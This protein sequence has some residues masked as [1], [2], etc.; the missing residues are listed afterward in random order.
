[1]KREN[2]YLVDGVLSRYVSQD[3][4]SLF[5]LGD[6]KRCESHVN[7]FAKTP[8]RSC[9]SDPILEMELLRVFHHRCGLRHQE[10]SQSR[11]CHDSFSCVVQCIALSTGRFGGGLIV[12]TDLCFILALDGNLAE[13]AS[14]SRP[15]TLAGASLW[16]VLSYKLWRL[17]CA[18]DHVRVEDV[19]DLFQV[20]NRGDCSTAQEANCQDQFG[21]SRVLPPDCCSAHLGFRV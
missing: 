16:S 2:G 1:M 14:R 18:I 4:G 3:V 19:P 17:S 13:V 21:G 5:P 7:E 6:R 8:A 10:R 20:G 12:P 9:A 15:T 11:V